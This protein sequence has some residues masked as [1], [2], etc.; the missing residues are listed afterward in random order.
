MHGAQGAA[1]GA[2]G[3]QQAPVAGEL[4]PLVEDAP[5]RQQAGA[6]DV[7]AGELGRLA[8]VDEE[9]VRVGREAPEVLDRDVVGGVEG[10]PSHRQHLLAVAVLLERLALGEHPLLALVGADRRVDDLGEE[11]LDR[12][13]LGQD[14]VEADEVEEAGIA[15]HLL[16]RLAEANEEDVAAEGAVGRDRGLQHLD[17]AEVDDVDAVHAQHQQVLARVRFEVVAQLLLDVV[18]RAE[19]QR[20]ADV[21][22]RELRADRA[23]AGA[24]EVA[25]ERIGDDLVDPR[26]AGA[27]DEEGEREQDAGQDREVERLGQGRGK[28]HAHDRA[29][30]ARG[31][32]HAAYLETLD[33]APRDGEQ[34][35]GDR[36]ARDEARVRREEQHAEHHGGAGDDAGHGGAGADLLRGGRAREGARA[37][38]TG[39]QPGGEV[40]EAL[41]EELLVGIDAVAV[42]AR[43]RLAGCDRLDQTEGGDGERPHAEVPDHVEVGQGVQRGPGQRRQAARDLTHH[44]D[45]LGFEAEDR[46]RGRG[47]ADRRQGRR[48]ARAEAPQEEQHGQ[49]PEPE[50]EA[51]G[52]DLVELPGDRQ[53]LVVELGRR[54]LVDPQQVLELAHRDVDRGARGEADED[55]ARGE[56]H[57]PAEA[58]HR[59][60]DVEDPD[61]QGEGARGDEEAG[62]ADLGDAHEDRQH[63]QR[64]RVDG[65]GR[66]EARRAPQRADGCGHRGGVEPGLRGQL[67]DR[68]VGDRLRDRHRRHRQAGDDIGRQVLPPVAPEDVERPPQVV[69]DPLRRLRRGSGRDLGLVLDGCHLK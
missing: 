48:H 10:D 18:D 56:R 57:Q 37:R 54:G 68:G 9:S 64:D 34:H 44:L 14:M 21:H 19:E 33:H 52:V 30:G 60:D 20:A 12:A 47:R 11:M 15:H 2:A 42:P 7:A 29:L 43:Q 1:A 8:D 46:D 35:A 32:Q 66:E 61:H 16:D 22:D 13:L 50:P 26:Q 31:P 49:G 4:R 28:G 6:W 55:C 38:V 63:E 69:A 41:A 40:G 62:A 23:V 51:Q 53:Q 3:E 45:P 65:P 36:R 67:G 59:E 39:E 27:D 5:Q 24:H 58:Q 25:E 17:A